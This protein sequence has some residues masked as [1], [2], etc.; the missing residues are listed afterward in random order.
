[1]CLDDVDSCPRERHDTAVIP[2]PVPAAS[3]AAANSTWKKMILVAIL[4]AGLIV[5]YA[6]DL[7]RYLSLETVKANRDRLLAYSEDHYATAVAGYLVVYSLVVALSLPGAA[8]LTLAGGFLFGPFLAVLYVN[9][10]ATTGSTLAFLTARYLF[11]DWVQAKF[12]H[13]LS[14]LQE[15]FEQNGFMYMLTLRLIPI[16]PF[17]VINL[18]AGLTRIPLRTYVLA[19]SIGII[20]GTFVYAYA[21]RQLGTINSLAEIATPRVLLAFMMLGLLAVAPLLYRRLLM[22]RPTASRGQ[23]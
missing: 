3:P 9:M 21:G 11:R 12:G 2:M 20:P 5:F 14:A 6:L 8:I 22:H 18:L 4:V 16:F 10:G 23:R 19:T 7:H 15:G 17:F 13:R 1:M